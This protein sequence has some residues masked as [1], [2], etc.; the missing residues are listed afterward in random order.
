MPNL[1]ALVL[2]FVALAICFWRMPQADRRH[3]ALCVAAGLI[4]C[5]L[6]LFEPSMR[7][8]GYALVVSGFL[9]LG[10]SQLFRRRASN[11]F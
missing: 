7:Q 8:S 10:L 6:P 9:V 11:G 2:F 5:A 3:L 1:I 4:W